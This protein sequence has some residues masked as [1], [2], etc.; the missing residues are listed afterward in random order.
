[1]VGLK[2]SNPRCPVMKA[3][4]EMSPQN[5]GLANL[6][7]A[8]DLQPIS[9]FL[10]SRTQSVVDPSLDSESSLLPTDLDFRN[11]VIA[12]RSSEIHLFWPKRTAHLRVG[13]PQPQENTSLC[14]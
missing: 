11:W 7:A 14:I 12:R 10:D 13:Q 1:M 8:M 4:A 5:G 6:L 2:P 9:L 3:L